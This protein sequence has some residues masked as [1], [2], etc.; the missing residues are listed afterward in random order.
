MLHTDIPEHVLSVKGN[1]VS[2]LG[3]I[4]DVTTAT[5]SS[6]VT[7]LSVALNILLD[8]HLLHFVVVHFH[9]IAVEVLFVLIV[10]VIVLKVDMIDCDLTMGRRHIFIV[11][12][13]IIIFIIVIIIIVFIPIVVV[14]IIIFLTLHVVV[15]CH[16]QVLAFT[17][18]NVLI[19]CILHAFIVNSRF[20]IVCRRVNLDLLHLL[21]FQ[22]RW[23]IDDS[24]PLD[25]NHLCTRQLLRSVR[26]SLCIG[27]DSC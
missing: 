23:C 19:R 3:Q 11:V 5:T 18:S 16:D 1:R 8:H 15:L 10:F 13:I 7:S 21:H 27:N 17:G 25:A 12:I 9:L 14:V 6:S 2:A 26:A 22:L 20:N 24:V 4:D